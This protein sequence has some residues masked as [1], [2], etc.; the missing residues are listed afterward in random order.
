MGAWTL[1]GVVGASLFAGRWVLQYG[2][3]R[4]AGRSVV[5]GTFW[6]A[7]FGGSCLQLAYFTLSPQRDVVG[8]LGSALPAAVAFY[9]LT[10]LMRPRRAHPSS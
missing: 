2:A 3:S 5:P 10:L 4:R 9:N 8:V 7:S 6:L 1:V